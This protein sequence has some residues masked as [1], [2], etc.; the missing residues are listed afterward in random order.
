MTFRALLTELHTS[1][2]EFFESKLAITLLKHPELFPAVKT[3]SASL[4]K[5]IKAN[6]DRIM[7][8]IDQKPEILEVLYNETFF[9]RFNPE[10]RSIKTPT[11]VIKT[12]LNILESDQSNFN[13]VMQVHAF[14]IRKLRI[15]IGDNPDLK[16]IETQIF[17]N[18]LFLNRSRVEF[19]N[20]PCTK[21]LGIVRNRAFYK[22]IG[23]SKEV[24]LRAA[25]CFKSGT[26]LPSTT[27]ITT[28]RLFVAGASG[29]TGELL[30]GAIL[31]GELSATRSLDALQQYTLAC[32]V[33]LAAGGNHSYF[34]VMSV[35]AK[36]GAP[37]EQNNYLISIPESIKK[38][39]IFKE[40]AKEFSQFLEETNDEKKE[41]RKTD[42]AT[43]IRK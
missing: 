23:E 25:D 18:N 20:I 30:L 19:K 40:L 29:H 28:D 37:Y 2:R 41:E 34:E 12:L 35:A 3:V 42:A 39:D 32:F 10:E 11:H 7:S 8:L 36:V 5:L 43:P 6:S 17:K 1:H 15:I 14:F 9:G 22:M 16:P 33:F 21:Q 31:Y 13:Q 24:H 27:M 4:I 38:T 26:D